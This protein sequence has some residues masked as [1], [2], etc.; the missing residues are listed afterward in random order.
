MQDQAPEQEM[1]IYISSDGNTEIRKRW[2]HAGRL[3][4]ATGADMRKKS[5][6]GRKTRSIAEEGENTANAV[7]SINRGNMT[8][9]V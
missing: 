5:R 8:N 9:E 6:L 7:H 4:R 2:H 3:N 1:A